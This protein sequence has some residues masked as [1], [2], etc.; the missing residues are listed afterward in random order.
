MQRTDHPGHT[1]LAVNLSG[2][3]V[4]SQLPF[5]VRDVAGIPVLHIGSV[6]G[7]QV[8]AEE[9]SRVTSKEPGNE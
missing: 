5:A 4:P 7:S 3:A 6:T 9:K 2:A 1:D 8:V